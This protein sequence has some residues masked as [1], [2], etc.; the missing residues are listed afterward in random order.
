[1]KPFSRRLACRRS[2]K[3]SKLGLPNNAFLLDDLPSS[4][5]GQCRASDTENDAVASDHH[6]DGQSATNSRS[7]SYVALSRTNSS[8][9]RTTGDCDRPTYNTTR[10]V[11]ERS[12]ST[13]DFDDDKQLVSNEYTLQ[14]YS[15]SPASV[16]LSSTEL[17][18]TT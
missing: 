1:M 10:V 15:T 14:Q 16:E 8:K 7:S 9:C 13:C 17:T 11:I 18:S 5:R 12:T 4:S 6:D 3:T 2:D